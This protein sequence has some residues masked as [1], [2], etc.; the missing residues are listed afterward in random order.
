MA[1]F[2]PQPWTNPFE[3]NF[4][5]STVITACFYSLEKRFFLVEYHKRQFPR[6]YCLK[7]KKMQKWPILDQNHGVTPLE[8][9]QFFDC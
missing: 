4:N 2:G 6:L 8:K 3:K 1:H 9:W 5:F 7:K